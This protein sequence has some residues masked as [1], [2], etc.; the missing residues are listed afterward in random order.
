MAGAFVASGEAALRRIDVDSDP[1]LESLYGAE[2][3]VLLVNGRKAFKYR[4]AHAELRRRIRA[5]KRRWLGRGWRAL[6]G[7]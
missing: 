1:G 4:V 2:V 7:G 5:E 6:M 3:P